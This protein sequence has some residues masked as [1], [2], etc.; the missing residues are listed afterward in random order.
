MLATF[1]AVAWIQ[2]RF[3]PDA[4]R[5]YVVSFTRSADDIAA[6]YELA[7][8]AMAGGRLPVLD[9][10]PLFE[11][12]ADLA[13]APD[14]LTGMLA[15]PRRSPSGSPPT[16]GRLE[17]MLGY[18]DSA[19]ELG[20][21][22]RHPPAL[23]HPGPAGRLGRGPRRPADLVPRP[24]RRARPGRRSGRPGRAGAGARLGR[25]VLQGHRA[26][27]GHL[28]PVR[29]AGDREA[30]PGAGR[31]RGAA[32]LVAA[33]RRTERGRGGQPTAPSPTGSTRPRGPPSAGWSRRTVSPTGSPGSARWGD[34][35]P[36]HRLPAGQARPRP[37]TPAGAPAPCRP[38]T[39]PTC[40]RS[41]GSSP[42]RR[43]G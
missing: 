32:R 24:G 26:G 10:V 23:R 1:R 38:W 15:L 19:K 28:R 25:R 8:Y 27:R 7:R 30:A 11:S 43:P 37:G 29:P 18:S 22:Q 34:R 20:P 39:W 4:C 33:D 40:G 16:A 9:V 36:A 35:R 6:V 42:G 5:R 21:G 12:A 17:A 2:D 14:V 41:R 31:L 13:N 3:G